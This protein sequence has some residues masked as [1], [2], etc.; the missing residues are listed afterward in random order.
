M[1]GNWPTVKEPN[2]DLEQFGETDMQCIK[3]YLKNCTVEKHQAK[4]I[5]ALSNYPYKATRS[6]SEN[7]H[8]DF[9]KN[10]HDFPRLE[11]RRTQT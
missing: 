10:W 2:L 11:N 4:V 3:R 9:L 8:V 5:E 1:L 7:L 6:L